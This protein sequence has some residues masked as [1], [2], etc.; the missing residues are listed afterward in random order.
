MACF[1][2]LEASFFAGFYRIFGYLC[3]IYYG[4][5]HFCTRC[6]RRV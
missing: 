3:R 4:G 5:T 2:H 6:K 1:R